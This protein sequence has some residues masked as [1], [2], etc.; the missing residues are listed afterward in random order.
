MRAE[1]RRLHSPDVA[2]LASW[3]P[4]EHDFAILVQ[5][6]VGPADAV[7][8]ESFDLTVCT[9]GWLEG[10]VRTEGIV[11]GRHHLLIDTYDPDRIEGYLRERVEACEGGSWKEVAEQVGRLGKWEFEDYRE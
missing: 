11:D 6:M 9:P 5:L 1:L 2:D 4:G 10:R 3:S 8:E 7:G